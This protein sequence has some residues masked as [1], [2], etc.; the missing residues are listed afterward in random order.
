MKYL[1]LDYTSEALCI[2]S[3]NEVIDYPEIFKERWQT[4]K[5]LRLQLLERNNDKLLQECIN[6]AYQNLTEDCYTF[7]NEIIDKF[8]SDYDVVCIE[9]LSPLLL[10]YSNNWN[11]FTEML[12]NKL[13]D[14]HKYLIKIDRYFPSTQICSNCGCRNFKLKDLSIRE[15]DCPNCKQHHNRDFNA[16][17]NIMNEG[18]R[19]FL[20][21]FKEN[22]NG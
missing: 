14:N 21:Q 10:L 20:K 1:G 8:I 7:F 17:I 19:I 11:I 2:T 4:L 22:N 5:D 6:S 9:T 15:W 16:A 18:K 3:E 12:N 13:I